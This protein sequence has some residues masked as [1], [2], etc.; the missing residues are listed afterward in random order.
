MLR[1][2][3]MGLRRRA[4]AA[5]AA[6][7]A[8]AATTALFWQQPASTQP[9]SANTV[10]F[11]KH[12]VILGWWP[13]AGAVAAN[14]PRTSSLRACVAHAQAAGYEGC[15]FSTQDIKSTFFNESTP[16]ATVI[17]EAKQVAPPGFFPGGT[18]HILDGNDSPYGGLGQADRP[19]YDW[20]SPSYWATIRRAL[21]DDVELGCVYATFQLFLPPRHMNTG[22]E[23]RNDET[24]LSLCAER[25]AKLQAL[26]HELGLNAYVETHIDRLSEDLEAFGK[27][28][29]RS[30]FFELN[31]DLSHYFYRGITQGDDL[32]RVLGRVGHMHARLARQYGDL[33]ADVPGGD[34]AADWEAKGVT[35]QAFEYYKPA[36]EGGLSSRCIMGESGPMHLVTDAL[37]LDAKLV[38]LWRAMAEYADKQSSGGVLSSSP[39]QSARSQ[40]AGSAAN[41]ISEAEAERILSQ[42]FNTTSSSSATPVGTYVP[43]GGMGE[44]E[45]NR[46]LQAHFRK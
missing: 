38:P 15:E 26:C 25:I 1:H 24:Y 12:R 31:A 5:A 8:A 42:H 36:L 19:L 13:V 18:Y 9:K 45:A 35:Y 39:A 40:P 10:L 7:A 28:M 46:I 43:S 14:D 37:G 2:P 22:G 16:T 21:E 30:P 27:I 44:A 17:A 29:D 41:N 34:P 20:N 32:H 4:A 23:Y 33:S 11:A 6:G 3:L